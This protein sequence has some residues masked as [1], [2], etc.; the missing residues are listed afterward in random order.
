MVSLAD[1]CRSP[2]I[3]P[4]AEKTRS[5]PPDEAGAAKYCLTIFAI[6]QREH[7]AEDGATRSELQEV[8]LLAI[9]TW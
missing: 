6:V 3:F 2:C 4:A 7:T 8:W 5:T 9:D 1:F